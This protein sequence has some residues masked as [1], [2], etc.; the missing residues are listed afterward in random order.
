MDINKV[1]EN[2]GNY[3]I[4]IGEPLNSQVTYTGEA[5]L[6]YSDDTAYIFDLIPPY[7][8]DSPILSVSMSVNLVQ[9]EN[10]IYGYH[11]GSVTYDQ[12]F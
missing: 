12:P 8:D 9:D 2:N 11:F 7:D 4:S 10:S 5:P 6:P 1:F 3:Y